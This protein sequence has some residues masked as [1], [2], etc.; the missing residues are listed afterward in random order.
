ML[1]LYMF[2]YDI[3]YQL[4]K[5]VSTGFFSTLHIIVLFYGLKMRKYISLHIRVNE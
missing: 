2:I 3:F 1:N 4:E 5:R